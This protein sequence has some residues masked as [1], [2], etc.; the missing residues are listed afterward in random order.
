VCSVIKEEEALQQKDFVLRVKDLMTENIISVDGEDSVMDAARLM[1]EKGLSSLAV[2]NESEHILQGI[3]T[4]RDIVNRV[5]AKGLDP[6]RV[7]VREVMVSPLITIS[8]E[9]TVDDAANKMKENKVRRLVVEKNHQKVGIIAESDIIRIDPELHFLI[10]ERAK[11]EAKPSFTEPSRLLL[12]G[13]CEECENYS[14]E[15][16]NISGMWLC[17]EC[18]AQQH[19]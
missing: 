6:T 19:A 2:R 1:S 16:R 3:I 15:L 4:D 8:E 9:A 17:E 5:V 11:L 13:F 10:R 14:G 12:A 18:R 7:K